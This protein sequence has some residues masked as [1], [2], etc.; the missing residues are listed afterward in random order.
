MYNHCRECSLWA[1]AAGYSMPLTVLSINTLPALYVCSSASYIVK[2]ILIFVWFFFSPFFTSASYIVKHILIFV[3]YF[4]SPFFIS[5]LSLQL[6]FLLL[7]FFNYSFSAN[8][9]VVII[10]VKIIVPRIWSRG[11]LYKIYCHTFRPQYVAII[12][13]SMTNDTELQKIKTLHW[14]WYHTCGRNCDSKV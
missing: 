6:V 7:L 1:H 14:G 2:Y 12:S 5:P 13:S 8:F 10:I 4:F 9:I 3:W 11:H